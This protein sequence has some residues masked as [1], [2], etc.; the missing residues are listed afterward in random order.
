MGFGTVGPQS[1]A[2]ANACNSA[3]RLLASIAIQKPDVRS[4]CSFFISPSRA[5]AIEPKTT[6][7]QPLQPLSTGQN[8]KVLRKCGRIISLASDHTTLLSF[9][10]SSLQRRRNK[11]P[12]P[13]APLLIDLTMQN[14]E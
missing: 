12:Q 10:D 2:P 4:V 1:A 8:G 14:R 6:L 7:L 3:W 11:I 9:Y 5:L 13:P